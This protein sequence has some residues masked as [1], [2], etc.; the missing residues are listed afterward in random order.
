MGVKRVSIQDY[1]AKFS[2]A[3]RGRKSV[4]SRNFEMA[5]GL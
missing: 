1:G 3:S 4:G 5:Y 2:D